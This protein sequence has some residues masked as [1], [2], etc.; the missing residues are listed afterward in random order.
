HPQN[1]EGG[2]GL[3][4][5]GR[6]VDP[7]SRA[8]MG[9]NMPRGVLG[10]C[11][12]LPVA[13]IGFE[14][15]LTTISYAVEIESCLDV[16]DRRGWTS[17]DSSKTIPQQCDHAVDNC[18]DDDTYALELPSESGGEVPPTEK[19]SADK[20]FEHVED[21]IHIEFV[22]E[23]IDSFPYPMDED[24]FEVSVLPGD[25]GTTDKNLQLL[26]CEGGGWD[27]ESNSGRFTVRALC[28]NM[29]RKLQQAAQIPPDQDYSE[30][31]IETQ[32]LKEGDAGTSQPKISLSVPETEEGI[33]IWSKVK[34]V[35]SYV[36]VAPAVVYG[37]LGS[38][39]GWFSEAVFEVRAEPTRNGSPGE[40]PANLVLA[41][42]PHI[43]VKAACAALFPR[44]GQGQARRHARWAA[45]DLLAEALCSH[46]TSEVPGKVISRPC[47]G[48]LEGSGWVG[49][50]GDCRSSAT[51]ADFLSV[52][53]DLKGAAH[54]VG[55]CCC[56][57][58]GLGPCL[59]RAAPGRQP[60]LYLNDKERGWK[61]MVAGP[62]AGPDSISVDSTVEFV[63]AGGRV[64]E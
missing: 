12:F 37:V 2:G 8:K 30:V 46:K 11:F 22:G 27:G 26:Q 5:S 49:A 10:A 21:N 1:S 58:G 47:L 48:A 52:F 55:S 19:G 7:F 29:L 57:P 38:M 63:T 17:S 15:L 59:L 6:G 44:Y 3:W 18:W 40:L 33:A 61:G 45:Q 35:A 50:G 31:E 20:G 43:L 34:V 42:E 39:P 32:H 25:T 41:Q 24:V 9:L 16:E 62:G 14:T 60:C 4:G 64:G 51:L 53:L 54:G 23:A 13:W 36:Q 56:A 28:D